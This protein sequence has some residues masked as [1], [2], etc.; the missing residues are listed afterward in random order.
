MNKNF[1]LSIDTDVELKSYCLVNLKDEKITFTSGTAFE[2]E[3]GWYNLVVQYHGEKVNI[4]DI[5]INGESIKEYIYTGFFT[6]KSTGKKFQPANSLWTEGFYSIWIHTEIGYMVQKHATSIRN[7]DYG[8]NLFDDYLFT[9]DKSIELDHNWPELIKSYF[10]HGNGPRWWKK[11]LKRTPYEVC[12]ESF[13][14]DCDKTKILQEIPIDCQLEKDY[15]MLS[16]SRENTEIKIM[17]VR[18]IRKASVYPYIEIDSLK[19][20]EIKKLIRRLGFTKI[21]NIT[22]Q[23]ALPG[24]AFKPHVDDHFTRDCMKD[25]EGPVVFLWDLSKDHTSHLFKLGVA[26]LLP[27]GKGVFFNQMYYDHGTINDSSTVERPL[28]IIH[29]KRDKEFPYT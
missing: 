27:L 10:R 21:L 11:D 13:L 2:L 6:E 26:G 20:E 15:P 22:L 19:G 23:T 29:G 24:Q 9:V 8:K 16:K 4:T 1:K 17:K 12:Q 5:K 7:G 25:I 28:L 3:T 18:A 14:N